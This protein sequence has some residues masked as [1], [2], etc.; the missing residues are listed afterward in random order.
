MI[1][2][3]KRFAKYSRECEK[4]YPKD[5]ITHPWS[6]SSWS[7]RFC[8]SCR[9]W[10]TRPARAAHGLGPWWLWHLQLS[11]RDNDGGDGGYNDDVVVVVI[12]MMM[13]CRILVGRHQWLMSVEATLALLTQERWKNNFSSTK[14]F[15][16]LFFTSNISY[17]EKFKT[18]YQI[19]FGKYPCWLRKWKKLPHQHHSFSLLWLF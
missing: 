11:G 2:R 16:I 14:K 8:W 7:E 18:W 4:W 10:A 15:V 6:P 13:Y 5:N 12:I 17:A 9:W 1:L 3:Y 19:V